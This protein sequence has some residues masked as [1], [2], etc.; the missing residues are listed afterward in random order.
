MNVFWLTGWPGNFLALL[1]ANL[2]TVIANLRNTV[3][4]ALDNTGHAVH[5][6]LLGD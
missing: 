5:L 2:L 3:G 4:G 6:F 1:K